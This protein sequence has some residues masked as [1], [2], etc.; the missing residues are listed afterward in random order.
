MIRVDR[1][2]RS[3]P[4]DRG[5]RSSRTFGVLSLSAAALLTCCGDDPTEPVGVNLLVN[6]GFELG[7][8]AVPSSWD[9]GIPPAFADHVDFLGSEAESRAGD[10][11]GMIAIEANHPVDD[12]PVH[13]NWFQS[14]VDGFTV[15]DTYELG[16]WIKTE[17][18]N[19]TAWITVLFLDID[20]QAMDAV[21]TNGTH[22][23]AGTRDWTSVDLPFTVPSGTV[24][25]L[26]R[27]GISA[28]ANAGGSVWFDDITITAR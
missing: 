25:L 26:V 22:N 20:L 15:G 11:S 5:R 16:A 3:R 13:Y 19:E 7:T 12:G 23:V 1:S 6:G 27:A 24:H 2:S 14:I 8:A 28:P 18:L 9:Q 21:T 10:R 17:D 4:V